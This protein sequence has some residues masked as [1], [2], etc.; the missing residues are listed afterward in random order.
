MQPEDVERLRDIQRRLHWLT[1]EWFETDKPRRPPWWRYEGR[2]GRVFGLGAG[3]W[4]AVAAAAVA[5]A[6]WRI[7]S[8]Y[9]DSRTPPE[10]APGGPPCGNSALAQVTF[11]EVTGW[12]VLGGTAAYRDAEAKARAVCAA[13]AALCPPGC[14]PGK[15]CKPNLSVQD[16]S[17]GGYALFS[18]V[19][20]TFRCPC[21]CY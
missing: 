12:S 6:V 4:A 3:A 13:N 14:A 5:F 19:S 18:T 8:E 15:T 10:P 1:R 17:Y 16:V 21:E 9:E 20:M 11:P 7:S 2:G